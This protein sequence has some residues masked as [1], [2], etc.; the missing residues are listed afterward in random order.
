M[1]KKLITATEFESVEDMQSSAQEGPVASGGVL[2]RQQ[3][4]GQSR[5]G[6]ALLITAAAGV[7]L[8]A[9]AYW[10]AIGTPFA[11]ETEAQ[12]DLERALVGLAEV[13]VLPENDQPILAAVADAEALKHQQAFFRGA[14]IGDQ[15]IIFPKAMKAVLWRPSE[16]I[17]VNTGPIQSSAKAAAQASSSAFDLDAD[18]T[19][20]G[21]T[22]DAATATAATIEVRNSTEQTGHA[23][24]VA[25]EL[26]H[27][28]YHVVAVADA[29]EVGYAET[30]VVALSADDKVAAE[31]L[32]EMLGGVIEPRLPVE[33]AP[34]EADILIILGG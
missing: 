1:P 32:A 18:A 28:G 12:T 16:D 31:H 4:F 9:A 21:T 14:V 20:S 23:A 8:V 5:F 3:L 22:T 13:M 11:T 2:L 24:A 10:F 7:I 6:K 27:A 30:I 19:A 33:E 17:I 15:L 25:D 26:R 29:S 34:T